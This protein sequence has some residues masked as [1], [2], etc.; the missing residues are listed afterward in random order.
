VGDIL[1]KATKRLGIMRLLKFKLDRLSLER[2][3][4]CFIRPVIEYADCV[5]DIPNPASILME[6]LE[7]FQLNAARIVTGATA[8]CESARLYLE[9]QWET[10]AKRRANHRLL[11][12]F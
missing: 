1:A 12:L 6:S 4:K 3:Y 10:L 7:K 11:Q 5:W 2:I 9:T 8:R